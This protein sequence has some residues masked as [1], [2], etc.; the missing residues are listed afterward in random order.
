MFNVIP[1]RAARNLMN[2]SMDDMLS[3][4]FFRHFFDM[5]DMVGTAGFRVDV[6]E[7]PDA[8]VL[9]AELPGVKQ[10]DITLT[11]EDGVANAENFLQANPNMKVIA[12]IGGGGSEVARVLNE[13]GSRVRVLQL[14]LPDRFVDHGDQAQLLA[15]SGLD[16]A[17]VLDRI[18]KAYQVN[19]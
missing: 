14:G 4:R 3:D 13:A 16:S 2:T 15:E 12:T 6:K 7:Q 10:D 11:A 18:K 1:F 8:Y 19:S 9:E 17:S 5:S